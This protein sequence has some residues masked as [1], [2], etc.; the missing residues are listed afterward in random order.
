M[1]VPL[2]LKNIKIQIALKVAFFI[3]FFYMI[4]N[5]GW[6]VKLLIFLLRN[7]IIL[8]FRVWQRVQIRGVTRMSDLRLCIH[9]EIIV[10]I[11]LFKWMVSCCTVFNTMFIEMYSNKYTTQNNEESDKYNDCVRYN[12]R[13]AVNY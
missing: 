3:H 4:M 8:W 12:K 7:F 10:P 11:L 2:M 9:F 5:D 1:N 6:Y 13:Q